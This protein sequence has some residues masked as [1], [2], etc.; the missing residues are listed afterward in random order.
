MTTPSIADLISNSAFSTLVENL[1]QAV[2]LETAD[3]RIKLVNPAFCALFRIP[4]QPEQLIGADCSNAADQAKGLFARPAEFVS[5]I[6]VLLEEREKSLGETLRMADGKVLLRDFIP[7]YN[8]EEFAGLLWTYTDITHHTH[9]EELEIQQTVNYFL[10]SLYNKETVDDILW[11]VARNCIGR[12]GFTDC[13]I[14]LLNEEGTWLEQKAAWGDKSDEE[15]RIISPI[16]IP[17]GKGIVGSVAESGQAEIIPDTSADKR[18]IIDDALRYSEITVPIISE[19]KVIGVID[20][21]HPE[22]NFFSEKHLSILTA[23]AS[24]CAIKIVHLEAAIDQ[25]Q[26]MER[27]KLFYEEILNN[28]PADIAVFDALHHYLFV[29]PRGIKD[30]DLRKWIIGRKDEDYCDLRNKPYSIFKERREYFNR[31]LSTRTQI[32]WEEALKDADGNNNYHLRKFYPVPD[33]NGLPKLVIGYGLNITERRL[34]EDQAER[35]KVPR[36]V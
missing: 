4:V 31:A 20:S 28:I 10:S 1:P 14:Y 17:V 11:D 21:E 19:G 12:L 8:E 2:L 29:N 30:D 5:R 22:K 26:E 18:Y 24:L 3:R 36:L 32:E 23:I 7:L 34:I 16:R 15:N 33:E 13:I 25:R 6:Q 35:E 9:T 27:Q